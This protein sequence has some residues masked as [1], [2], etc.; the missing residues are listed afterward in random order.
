MKQRLTAGLIAGYAV[1][2]ALAAMYLYPFLIAV[3]GSFKTDAEATN[4]PLALIPS[5]FTVAAYERLFFGTDLPRWAMNSVVIA[6]I[7]TVS[8]V[9]FNSLAGYALSRLPFRGRSVVFSVFIAVLAVP[10]VVLMVPRFLV[11]KELG[12]FDTYFGMILPLLVDAAGIFIM[13]QFFDSIP[14]SIEEAARIDGAGVFRRFWS[15]TL[16]M[17]TPALITLTIL[18]FQGSW[19]EFAHFII[20]RQSP[21]LHT[22]TTG[23]G[24]LVSGQLGSGNQ[25]PLKLAAAVLMTIPV[26]ILFFIF[27]RRIMSTTEG[28][29]KG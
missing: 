16:P 27:Q 24:A 19:N 14:A 13:K 28:A 11:I 10:S 21:E 18:S 3:M 8:R 26:A 25:F 22:L 29:E 4:N 7:V 15:V 20:S 17:A 2:I 23:V 5:P 12:M 1:L 9:F 6:V